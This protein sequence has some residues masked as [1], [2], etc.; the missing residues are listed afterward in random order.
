MAEAGS[1]PIGWFNHSFLS[2]NALLRA[3]RILT[4]RFKRHP[5]TN[6]PLPSVSHVVSHNSFRQ[7]PPLYITWIPPS[8]TLVFPMIASNT[9]RTVGTFSFTLKIQLRY[10]I[11]RYTH[12]RYTHT[13]NPVHHPAKIRSTL[14]GPAGVAAERRRSLVCS[15]AEFGPESCVFSAEQTSRNE[16]KRDD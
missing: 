4:A 16:V 5:I 8:V 14:W 12:F 9:E 10:K 7:L 1:A 13:T 15:R 11:N 6:L 3:D 2:Q